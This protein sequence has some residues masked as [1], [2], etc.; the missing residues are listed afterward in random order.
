MAENVVIA[1]EL[2]FSGLEFTKSQITQDWE[3]IVEGPQLKHYFLQ[4]PLQNLSRR[5]SRF[6]EKSCRAKETSAAEI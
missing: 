6:G 1:F 4:L 2:V 3:V 5:R